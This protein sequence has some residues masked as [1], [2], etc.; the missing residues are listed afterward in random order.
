MRTIAPKTIC[1]YESASVAYARRRIDV[2]LRPPSVDRAPGCGQKCRERYCW[3]HCPEPLRATRRMRDWSG[4]RRISMRGKNGAQYRQLGHRAGGRG[5]PEEDL[6][7][8]QAHVCHFVGA[9]H[10]AVDGMSR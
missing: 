7:E 9:L 1:R 10:V 3:K 4:R 8:L 2:T 5:D 6:S